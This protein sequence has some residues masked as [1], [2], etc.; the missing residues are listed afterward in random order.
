[1]QADSTLQN[2]AQVSRSEKSRRE[3]EKGKGEVRYLF[4]LSTLLDARKLAYHKEEV[5]QILK[6]VHL[7]ERQQ[8]LLAAQRAEQNLAEA[9]RA[10][11]RSQ[12]SLRTLVRGRNHAKAEYPFNG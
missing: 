2:Q 8:V 1:M 6:C 9:G 12:S 7:P 10:N 3:R 11:M 5:A 4:N